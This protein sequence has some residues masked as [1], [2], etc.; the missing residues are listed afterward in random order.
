MATFED[1]DLLPTK[2]AAEILNVSASFLN[3]AQ[4]GGGGPKFIKIGRSVKYR[5]SDLIGFIAE[6]SRLSTSVA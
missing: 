3:K 6:K 5:Y 4:C 1:N 2:R